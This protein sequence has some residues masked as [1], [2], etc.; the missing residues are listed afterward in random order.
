MKKRSEY[1]TSAIAKDFQ[2]WDD[3]CEFTDDTVMTVAV[4]AALLIGGRSEDFIT[5]M[6]EF[7]EL[8]PNAGYGG[9][10]HQWL[11]RK[12]VSPYNSFG[13]RRHLFQ[14]ILC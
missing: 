2:L 6:Q 4:A 5:T 9:M 13:N 10:F 3:G 11:S 8:Y 7:G 14:Y 1:T 12:N